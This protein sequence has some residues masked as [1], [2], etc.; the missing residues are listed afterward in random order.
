MKSYISFLIILVASFTAPVSA[1]GQFISDNLIVYIHSGPSTQFRIIGSLNAGSPVT[2]KQQDSEAEFTQIQDTRGRIGWVES[3]FVS[4]EPPA[5]T[6]LPQLQQ[7]LAQT[8]QTL[9]E[10]EQG[11]NQVLLDKDHT[12]DQQA[13]EIKQL[14]E[15]QALLT[16]DI[17]ALKLKNETLQTRLDNQ[18]ETVQMQWLIRGAAVLGAGIF[19]GL[20]IPFLPRRKKKDPNWV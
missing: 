16:Q 7:E 10:A 5:L 20:V 18:S 13:N 3:K 15:Q 6:L 9:A 2:I 8:K 17:E 12:I 1:Q 19:L 4:D 14:L 11:H